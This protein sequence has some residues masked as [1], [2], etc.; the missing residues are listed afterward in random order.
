[1]HTNHK[2]AIAEAKVRADL[3]SRGFETATPD[4]PLP[5]DLVVHKDGKL[6]KVQIKY[7]TLKNGCLEIGLRSNFYSTRKNIKVTHKF[8]GEDD[9]DVIAGYS[10][11]TDECF[12][13]KNDVL[14]DNNTSVVLRV[15]EPRHYVKGIRWARDYKEFPV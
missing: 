14:K 3:L 10:P 11:D 5:F 1:M 12:Y 13:V 4:L 15:K 9:F 2:G 8:Y 7:C 6:Y